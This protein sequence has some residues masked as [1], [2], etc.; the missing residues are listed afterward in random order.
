[1]PLDRTN[2]VDFL[3]SVGARLDDPITL[4]AAGGTALVLFDLKPS[5]RDVD[6]T[7][8]TDSIDRFRVVLDELPHGFKVDTWKE[9][10]VFSTGLPAD[11]LER[12]RAIPGVSIEGVELLALDPVDLVV[13]KIGRL[14]ER[15]RDDIRRARDAFDLRAE[16]VER[17]AGQ[18]ALAGNEENYRYHLKLILEEIFGDG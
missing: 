1:M 3:A 11:Y 18:V 13:T 9:G 2:L 15:D 17:R 5:T 6:F 10:A 7:G 14:N 8:P 4:V 12:A 16:E